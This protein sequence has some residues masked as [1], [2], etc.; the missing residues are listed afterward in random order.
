MQVTTISFVETA[1][2]TDLYINGEHAA[3]FA[4]TNCTDANLASVIAGWPH[5]F[6]CTDQHVCSGIAFSTY[7][8]ITE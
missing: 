8:P 2:R 3:T 1:T 5:A 6:A 7:E 4:R